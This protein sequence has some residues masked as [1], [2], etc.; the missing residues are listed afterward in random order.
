MLPSMRIDFGD[1][2][3]PLAR[4]ASAAGMTPRRQVRER[5]LAR[6]DADRPPEPKG[7]TFSLS[8][9]FDQ[10]L[11]H[12]VPGI[13]V[14]VLSLNSG[15]TTLLL[16]VAAGTRFPEHHHSG[17]EDCYVISGS[18]FTWGRR[19]T[20]GDFLHA[21]PGSHHTEMWTAEGCQVLLIVPPDDYIPEPAA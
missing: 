10:W 21:E 5:L 8:A 14:R 15:Y 19:L 13:R 18:L 9:Q 11:P 6:I 12:A 7:F 3:V 16:D 1:L 20:A 17:A 4:L 2:E